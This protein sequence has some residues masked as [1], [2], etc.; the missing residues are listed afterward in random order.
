MSIRRGGHRNR[1]E[2]IFVLICESDVDDPLRSH[3]AIIF[4]QYTMDSEEEVR[5]RAQCFA[6]GHKYGRVWLGKVDIQCEVK[7]SEQPVG[8]EAQNDDETG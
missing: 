3:G 5:E 6:N 1:G 2:S 4:E 8:N 7:P